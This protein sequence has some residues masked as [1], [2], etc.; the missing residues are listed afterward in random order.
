MWKIMSFCNK[1]LIPAIIVKTEYGN[2]WFP[3][4]VW[5]KKRVEAEATAKVVAAAPLMLEALQE[6]VKYHSDKE[7]G[8]IKGHTLGGTAPFQ[9][10]K[11]AIRN[12]TKV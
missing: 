2:I 11:T 10:A 4:S 6:I 7:T 3:L 1:K 9:L 12:A 8:L 5:S